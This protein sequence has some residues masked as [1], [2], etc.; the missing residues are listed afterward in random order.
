MESECMGPGWMG[1]PFLAAFARSGHWSD[2]RP[3]PYSWVEQ[4]FNAAC[5][6]PHNVIPSTANDEQRE[7]FAKSRNLQLLLTPKIDPSSSISALVSGICSA[8]PSLLKT[9]SSPSAHS[10]SPKPHTQH[11]I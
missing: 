4:R 9:L 3:C 6:S 5:Q 7:S 2:A 11:G 10:I 1:A 8:A